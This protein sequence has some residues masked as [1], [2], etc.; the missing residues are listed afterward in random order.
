ML[1]NI[2]QTHE[3]PLIQQNQPNLTL[4]PFKKTKAQAQ[5]QKRTQTCE[6]GRKKKEQK[7]KRKK[8]YPDVK[9]EEKRASGG[10][11]ESGVQV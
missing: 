1:Q 2:T 4:I 11:W 9:K 5:R 7:R 6:Q 3:S 8:R 10:R